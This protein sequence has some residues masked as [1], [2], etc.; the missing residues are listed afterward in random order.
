MSKITKL[1]KCNVDPDGRNYGL[2]LLYYMLMY[3]RWHTSKVRFGSLGELYIRKSDLDSCSIWSILCIKHDIEN[4]NIWSP[5]YISRI[6]TLD[7]T[8]TQIVIVFNKICK[9]SKAVTVSWDMYDSSALYYCFF[10][11]ISREVLNAWWDQNLVILGCWP[12]INCYAWT[13][14]TKTNSSFNFS[15]ES[16]TI[17]LAW[18]II[19]SCFGFFFSSTSQILS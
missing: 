2:L 11:V 19:N 15:L 5:I 7:S 8:K 14:L 17:V 18:L 9:E 1:T 12:P 6:S 4:L 16:C 13:S 10:S 3:I